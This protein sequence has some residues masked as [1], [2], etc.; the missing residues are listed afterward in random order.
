MAFIREMRRE[1]FQIVLNQNIM[2]VWG[3]TLDCL[4]KFLP[5][6]K[7]VISSLQI[8]RLFIITGKHLVT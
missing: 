8:R 7:Q 4:S 3:H 6:F 5:H 2:R 1:Y